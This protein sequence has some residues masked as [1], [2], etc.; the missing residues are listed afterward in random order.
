MKAISLW[1]PYAT[2]VVNGIKIIETRSW[3]TAYRG[4]LIIHASSTRKMMYLLGDASWRRF[5][6]E[7]ELAAERHFPLGALVGV[8]E[9]HDVG[10]VEEM[11]DAISD[12]ERLLGDYSD[13]R[14]A[15]HFMLAQE[16]TPAVPWR[17]SQG[18]FNVDKRELEKARWQLR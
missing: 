10:P 7:A 16:F 12:R 17:G 6:E 2:C 5:L 15:W 9:L 11:R 18:L 8:V 4:P 3:S 1:Q 14:Q 13:G